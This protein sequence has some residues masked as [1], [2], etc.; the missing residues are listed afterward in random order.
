MPTPG[1]YVT[2]STILAPVQSAA[3]TDAAGV[4]A[5]ELPQGPSTLTLV[6]SWYQ[7]SS[8]YGGL[9]TNYVASFGAQMFF[10]AGGTELYVQ[11]IVKDDADSAAGV[12]KT[13]DASTWITFTAKGAGAYGNNIR[14]KLV[15]NSANL[16][17]LTV[18]KE[19]GVADTIV[20]GLVTAGSGDDLVLESFTN[21]N[22]N[23]FGH[24]DVVN[25]LSHRSNYVSAEWEE[26]SSAK[27]I[28][29]GTS[30]I[31]PLSGGSD[32][33][34]DPDYSGV[35]AAI[36]GLNRPL[37]IFSPGLTD[38]DVID[39]FSTFAAAN[40][41]FVVVEPAAD[42]T[43]TEA[44]TFAGSL[45][46]SAFVGVYAPW[47]WVADPT[48]SARDAICK[49]P[50]SGAV[51]GSVLATDSSKGVFKTPAGPDV[52]VTGVVALE[53]EWT[54][55][56]LNTLAD[57]SPPV[58]AIRIIPGVGPAI[59]GGRTT[60]TTDATRF[61]NI[62]RSLNQIT[63]ELQNRLLFAVYQNNDVTLWNQVKT[64]VDAYLTS[65][66]QAGGLRGNVKANAFYVKVDGEN[67]TATDIANG[68]LNVEVGVALQ[69]PAEFIRI[70]LTQQ[71][72]I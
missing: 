36:G 28:A 33:S 12:L 3:V 35:T 55:T 22:L 7:F 57:G 15:K 40:G 32:G 70:N 16:W 41:S 9:S 65:F 37:V 24:Q 66:W 11:R 44:V 59:M 2:E 68:V 19:A 8:I 25:I 62:R 71:T 49:V 29:S 61:I 38:T 13:T 14:V 26:A 17:D 58:N 54:S 51:A 6:T 27:T 31:I 10:R 18:L 30:F 69:Y 47:V 52:A 63:F 50:P 42:S 67:N 53:T 64:V 60:K 39:E 21:L 45:T 23:T 72:G 46:S 20:S 48:S 43:A 34:G 5:A 4:L 56:D 1:V